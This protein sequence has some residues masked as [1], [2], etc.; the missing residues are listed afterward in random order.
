MRE[1]GGYSA[2]SEW[3]KPYAVPAQISPA[4]LFWHSVLE[5]HTKGMWAVPHCLLTPDVI[6][7]SNWASKNKGRIWNA[8]PTIAVQSS[9]QPGNS[10]TTPTEIQIK[11]FPYFPQ[12]NGSMNFPHERSVLPLECLLLLHGAQSKTVSKTSWD[13]REHESFNCQRPILHFNA[14]S[15]RS[16]SHGLDFLTSSFLLL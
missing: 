5:T 6:R 7:L 16:V 12:S 4:Y 2:V 9:P 10:E 8:L 3:L 1:W 11:G 13:S 14:I 15:F